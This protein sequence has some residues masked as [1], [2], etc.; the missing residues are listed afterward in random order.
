MKTAEDIV[1]DKQSDIVFISWDQTVHQT[2]RKMI[3]KKIGAIVIKKDDEFVGIWSERDLLRNICSQGFDPL[4]ARVS[5][6]MSAPLHSASHS[7]RIHKLEEMFLGLFLRHLMIEKDGEYIGMLSI[8]D[9]LRAGLLAKH[10]QFEELNEF[11]SWDYYENW[12]LGR[13]KKR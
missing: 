8:G 11:V 3:E 1:I 5:D 13:S 6:Y 2:C 4:T 9:V 10:R 12:Q 7:T